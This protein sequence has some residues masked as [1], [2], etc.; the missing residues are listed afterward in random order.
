MTDADHDM[1]GQLKELE[2]CVINVIKL[3]ITFGDVHIVTN[4]E[5]GWV[6]L[7]AQVG[8]ETFFPRPVALIRFSFLF[9]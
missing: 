6:Q 3:A 5:T 1:L 4:A 2:T 9:C 8:S 7:S